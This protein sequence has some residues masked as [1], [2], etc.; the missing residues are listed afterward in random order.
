MIGKPALRRL[1][2]STMADVLLPI[3]LASAS[4][5][6]RQMLEDAGVAF[7]IDPARIDEG[8][9]RRAIALSNPAAE[10]RF[11]ASELAQAKALGVSQRYPDALVIGS[12]QI[13]NLGTE[14]LTKS[15][16]EAA[17]R[18]TLTRL[19]GRTHELHSA[20]ALARNGDI[21]WADADSARLTMRSF[22]D[23]FLESYLAAEGADLFE[24]VGAFKLEGRGLQLFE[25]I[26]GDYF[27]I[28]GMPL[29]S[30]LGELRQHNALGV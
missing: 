27:T 25:T 28:L 21:L 7:K 16:N 22:S 23:E 14:I 2:K 26:K 3:V 30:L 6:R 8:A 11:V 12:D 1:V 17:A 20:V 24:A 15:A 9:I 18:A 19:R 29:L 10:P 5:A 4:S 13:L